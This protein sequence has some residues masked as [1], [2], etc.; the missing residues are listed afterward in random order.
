MPFAELLV[1]GFHFIAVPVPGLQWLLPFA[2]YPYLPSTVA[3]G[4]LSF[5]LGLSFIHVLNA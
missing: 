1:L 3:I 2:D 5:V 4:S